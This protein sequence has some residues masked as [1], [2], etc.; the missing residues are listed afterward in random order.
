MSRTPP[1]DE[2]EAI[3]LALTS[4]AARDVRRAR[5][6]LLRDLDEAGRR[7]PD[8][9]WIAGQRV[10]FLID[11]QQLPPAIDVAVRCRGDDRLCAELLAL[12]HYYAG[13]LV[14][15]DSALRIA[16]AYVPSP[17]SGTGDCLGQD[18]ISLF[19]GG[20]AA[21]VRDLPCAEEQRLSGN[22]WWLSDPLWTIPGNERYVAH[23]IHRVQIRLHAVNDR[24][25][26]SVWTRDG[27]REAVRETV[28][29]YGWPS[30]T[31]LAGMVF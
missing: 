29:R 21:K 15:A 16:D 8:D 28:I 24:E 22:L 4:Q 19:E 17:P 14:S 3:D 7:D 12:A 20:S 13:N 5:E 10:R 11:E 1:P 6:D 25:E 2:G 18:V 30:H 9:T 23:G 31:Y 26:R 27:G